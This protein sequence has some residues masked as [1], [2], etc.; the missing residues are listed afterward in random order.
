MRQKMHGKDKQGLDYTPLYHFLQSKVGCDWDGVFQEAR[1]RLKG[2]D[3]EA[4]YDVVFV[5]T[6]RHPN[7]K[8]ATA[9]STGGTFRDGI[10]RTDE[11]S[12]FSGLYID[13]NTVPMS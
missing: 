11:N 13:P 3:E 4:I 5:P 1:R 10:V 6:G 9:Y 8:V 7:V 12:Y 2:A